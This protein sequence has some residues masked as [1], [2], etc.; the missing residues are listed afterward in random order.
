[1]GAQQAREMAE[2]ADQRTALTWHLRGNH[3]PPV[4][5]EMVDP[6]IEAIE[7]ANNEDWGAMIKLPGEITWRGKK[8]APA[9]AIIEAHH[10]EAWIDEAE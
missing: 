10:L 9:S 2:L 5:V 7:A 6:C 4:P 3:Y 1:M 8:E